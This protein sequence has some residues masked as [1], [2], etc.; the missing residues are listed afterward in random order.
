M[1]NYTYYFFKGK[2]TLPDFTQK[3]ILVYRFVSH[4]TT[5]QL[6]LKVTEKNKVYIIHFPFLI[7]E[8]LYI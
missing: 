7:N 6:T 1:N 5:V 4:N 3:L 8:I 2:N